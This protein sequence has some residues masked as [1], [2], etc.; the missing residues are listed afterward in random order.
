MFSAVY[1]FLTEVF[2]SFHKELMYIKAHAKIGL[3]DPLDSFACV[4]Q[5]QIM[6]T[7]KAPNI[8]HLSILTFVRY[9]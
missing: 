1:Q 4:H 8:A 6:H 5:E 2:V 9:N 7:V 3:L